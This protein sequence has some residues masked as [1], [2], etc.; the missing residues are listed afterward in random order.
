MPGCE[1]NSCT[2]IMGYGD[3]LRGCL[4]RGHLSAAFCGDRP[5]PKRR[6][7]GIWRERPSQL[8][9][10]LSHGLS[11]IDLQSASFSLGVMLSWNVCVDVIFF[12][13]L[14]MWYFGT[15]MLPRYCISCWEKRTGGSQLRELLDIL[16]SCTSKPAWRWEDVLPQSWLSKAEEKT[17]QEEAEGAQPL[18]VARQR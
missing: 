17:N 15:R 13:F 3:F 2:V 12:L 11:W 7:E 9:G 8:Q 18:S 14:Y 10:R 6:M 4:N 5:M 1:M 16:G